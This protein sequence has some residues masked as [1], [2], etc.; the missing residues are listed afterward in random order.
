MNEL[1]NKGKK[2]LFVLL[3]VV[4]C[5]FVF[6]CNDNDDSDGNDAQMSCTATP[7]E[8]DACEGE[9]ENICEGTALADDFPF[10]T[11]EEC[12]DLIQ[13]WLESDNPCERAAG[14]RMNTTAKIDETCHTAYPW[15]DNC[16]GSEDDYKCGCEGAWQ[17]M[18]EILA[19]ANQE[20]C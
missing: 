5:V 13:T 20:D 3:I 8:S 12:K 15:W 2:I 6:S 19:L 4:V 17:Y 11:N 10:S 9:L 1:T 14:E 16:G 7:D 18:Q